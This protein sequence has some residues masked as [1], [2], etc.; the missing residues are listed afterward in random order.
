MLRCY[1]ICFI[2]GCGLLSAQTATITGEVT[3]QT[4][5]VVAQA[6]VTAT[7]TQ[8]GTRTSIVSNSAG[9]YVIPFVQP[10]VYD[11]FVELPGFRKAVRSG[12]K[13]DVDQTARVDF[14]LQPGAVAESVEVTAAAPLL[15]TESPSLGEQISNKTVVSLPLNG[16]DYTQ[17]VTLSPGA[18]PNHYSRTSNGFSLNGG[19]TLQTTL[20]LDGTDNTN[21]EIGTDTGN[22][23]ALN[24]SID[25]IQEFKV[26][27]AN[28]SAEYGRSAN[29][30]VS[31]SIKS[32]TNGFHGD[33]FEFLRNDALDANDWFANR[34]GL[35]RAPLRRNQYGGTLG[36]P[37]FKNHTFFF[38]SYQG[39][40]QTSSNTVTVTVPTPAML[41]GNFGN[42]KVKD[43]LTG[44]PFPNN[45]IPPSRFDPVG[46]KLAALYPPP[47]L[48]GTVNNFSANQR[49]T[50][51]ADEL[52]S[53]F[54]QQFTERDNAFFR[55]SRGTGEIDQASLFAPPGNGGDGTLNSWP[56]MKPLRA[57]SMAAGETHIFSS[58]LVND[59]HTGYTHNSSNQLDTATQ[60]LYSQFGIQGVPPSPLI[61]GLPAVTLTGYSALGDRQWAPNLKQVQVAQ[62]ND[63]V[64]WNH[65]SHNIRFGGEILYTYN[66]AFSANQ[67]RGVF[68]FNGQFTGSAFGDLLLGQTS[69]ASLGTVQIAHLRNR[70]YGLFVND[71]WKITPRLTVN[72]GL[73]YDLQTPW[74][75]RDNYQT[76]FDYTFGSPTFGTLVPAANG[77]IKNR[78]FVNPDTNNF[79]PR[80]GLAY[81]LTS[82]TVI[83]GAFGI[84]YGFPGYTGNNDT[85]TANPP[86]LINVTL[87]SPTTAPV[88]SV[89]LSQGFPIGL[90]N[91]ANLA[92]PNIF[93][94]SANFPMPVVDQWNFSVQHQFAGSMSATV[95]YVGSS[96]SHIA[97]LNDIN[98]PAPGPGAVN[99][100]RPF[101][102]WGQIEYETP[103]AHASY[104]GLQTSFEKRFSKGIVATA[105]YTYSHSLDNVLNHEDS[106]GGSFPQD[107]TDTN[108]ERASSGYD[109]RHRFVTSFAYDLP[110]GTSGGFLGGSATSRAI[111]GGW[112]TGAIFVAQTGYPF[113]PT[114]SPNPA[115]TTGAARPNRVCNGN[116]PSDRRSVDMWFNVSCF[117]P[118]TPFLF[119]NS[120]RDVLEAPGLVNVDLLVSRKFN[121]T[122]ARY[123]E[124]RTEFFN[125]TNSA[126]FNAP[127]A[128]IGTNPS[129]KITTTLPGSPD[130]EIEFAL[131]FWF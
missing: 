122:E 18:T 120:G 71:S 46:A 105:S 79:A 34:T 35:A 128:V 126:H 72:L 62:L 108:A 75:D 83:R 13:L 86:D 21:Y 94:I 78:S 16:R 26:E 116:L 114:V 50:N 12:I 29:G 96:T 88:S 119:G 1:V 17:L 54:D 31:V 131:K 95:A 80:A 45:I 69:S 82:H 39:T 14:V 37:I 33:A 104:Q 106:V 55:Y 90:L 32:G 38:V 43:P 47:N 68:A 130:R 3:D 40:R 107:R 125:L 20:L 28:F 15:Q 73:R 92:N 49:V 77:S 110:I 64:S 22:I 10:G 123:V 53:R 101:P 93:G 65:G 42:I 103:Y 117:A 36:G 44:Q 52:D 25:A 85:G 11:L 23:N 67:P 5:G 76:N 60:N 115:N 109:L 70:Y 7:N 127:N 61:N 87:T 102:Q 24:P 81:Q 30:I 84:F 27:T 41:D 97:G 58:N 124:F 74:W 63:T 99:P 112:Q 113:T 9:T 6:R 66:Y 129:G 48:P 2:V 4:G 91:P 100:R 51:S 56:Y 8:T 118:A 111:L 57:W 121:F 19:V 89:V 59:L 98:Q